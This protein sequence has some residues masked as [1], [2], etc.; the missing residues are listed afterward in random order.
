MKLEQNFIV[1]LLSP[2]FGLA[3]PVC[4]YF[5]ATFTQQLTVTEQA[6]LNTAPPEVR[7]MLRQPLFVED[8]LV[9]PVQPK[10]VVSQSAA[11]SAYPPVPLSALAPLAPA[12]QPSPPDEDIISMILVNGEK[13]LAIIDGTVVHEGERFRDGIIAGIEERRVLL[14]NGKGEKWLQLH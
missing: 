8:N 3:V 2:V 1:T 5:T 10:T 4:V 6:V 7:L 11:P 14:R 9:C 13:R 12:Q